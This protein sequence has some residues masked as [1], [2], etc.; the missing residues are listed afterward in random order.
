MRVLDTET[1]TFCARSSHFFHVY[2]TFLDFLTRTSD[3]WIHPVFGSQ[4]CP[5]AASLKGVHQRR[6]GTA[7]SGGG[8]WTGRQHSRPQPGRVSASETLPPQETIPTSGAAPD[9]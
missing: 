5:T 4:N 7:L 6:S 9:R 3:C 8:Y 2:T 1:R